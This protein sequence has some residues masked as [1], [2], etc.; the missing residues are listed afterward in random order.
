MIIYNTITRKRETL[1]PL[2]EGH[3]KMYTCG[4]TVYN[5]SH[6]GNF[7]AYMFEDILRRQLRSSGFEVTQIMNLTDVDDKT[8]RGAIQAG[9]SLGEFTEP[10]KKSF[11]ADLKTLN[12]EPAELY[13]EAT[14]HINEMITLVERLIDRGHAYVS[15]DGSVYYNVGGFPGYG[16]LARLDL[17]GLQAGARVA[18]DEYD[19]ENVGDFAVWKAWDEEDGEVAWESPWGRGRPGWHTECSAMSMNYLGERFDLHTGGVDNIF[20]HHEN[21][22]AQSE[23]ATGSTPFVK[24]WMH[25]GYLIVD[26]AKMSK[27]RGNF[28]TLRDLI[29]RGYSGRE[30]RYV[31]ISAHYRQSLNFTFTALDAARSS[32]A[33][34]DDFRDRLTDLSGTVDGNGGPSLPDW[35]QR[36]G[37]CF[38]E[39]MNDDLNTPEALG[40]LFEMVHEGNRAMD[41]AGVS[42]QHSLVVLRELDAMD[43]VLGVLNVTDEAPDDRVLAFVD[44]RI[45]ARRNK[46]WA[47]SDRIRDELASAGWEVRDTPDGPKLKK[48]AL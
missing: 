47:E 10:Y 20:P 36:G 19:K 16:R 17:S 12:I 44:A 11:F 23:G 1:V 3:V 13:P 22:I 41:D 27:S 21:E 4:P 6:I 29:E 26:G 24:Y 45:V 40:A 25:C 9:V 46:D 14:E 42:Q 8:I 7:R 35:A 38:R 32:L 37:T 43:S 18:H 48:I 30:V 39:A 15:D 2:E 31:L 34:L 28:Y 5:F 33:R